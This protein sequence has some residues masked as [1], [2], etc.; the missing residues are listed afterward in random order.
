MITAI[1]MPI[2]VMMIA[3]VPPGI[4]LW[5]L[6]IPL[7][8]LYAVAVFWVGFRYRVYA[9]CLE[10]WSPL[11]VIRRVRAGDIDA[12]ERVPINALLEWGGWGVRG[13]GPSKAY[14]LGG[15]EAIRIDIG[16]S[17]IWL[18]LKHADALPDLLSRLARRSGRI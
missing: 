4:L 11:R 2:V 3:T 7:I 14:V 8:L 12:V 13:I 17:R 6:P 5:L 18:G 1:V 15:G 9:D 10:I 16:D